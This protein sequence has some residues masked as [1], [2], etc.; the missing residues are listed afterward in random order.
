MQKQWINQPSQEGST[1][2]VDF[3]EHPLPHN[4]QHDISTYSF[5]VLILK[6]VYKNCVLSLETLYDSNGGSAKSQIR[7]HSTVT[8]R[9]VGRHYNNI[10][11]IND[12]IFWIDTELGEN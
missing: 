3:N 1:V 10:D 6:C 9:G 12:R 4:M 7:H 2:F 11:I 8:T 5:P